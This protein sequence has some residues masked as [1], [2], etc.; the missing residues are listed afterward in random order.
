MVTV[1]LDITTMGKS[2]WMVQKAYSW[3]RFAG[4][5]DASTTSVSSQEDIT[6]SRVTHFN[7]SLASIIGRKMRT[8]T[9][10][11]HIRYQGERYLRMLK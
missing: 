2:G 7:F 10:V 5:F 6:A 1:P 11:N 9:R 8:D 4:A 3:T